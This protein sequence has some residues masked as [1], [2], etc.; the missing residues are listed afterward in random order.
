M[1][2]VSGSEWDEA[3]RLVKCY[4]LFYHL[5]LG[6]FLF[7]VS[8]FLVNTS[9]AQWYKQCTVCV[10]RHVHTAAGCRNCC[11]IKLMILSIIL[12]AACCA[13]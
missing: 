8:V 2:L 10:Y 3:L 6:L 13:D 5:S 4:A 12:L 1:K 9:I 11:E 7:V